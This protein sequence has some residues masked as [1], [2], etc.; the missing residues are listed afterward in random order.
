MPMYNL[1]E[2]SKNYRK[3]T[4]SLWIYYRDEATNGA[5]GNMNY[6]LKDSKIID[7]KASII[8]SV[9]DTD[10]TKEAV[11]T[12]VPLKCLSIFWKILNIPLV[13]CEISLTLNWSENCVLISKAK[14]DVNYTA[15]PILPKINTPANATFETTDAKLYVPIV[16]SRMIKNF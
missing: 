9:T 12:F 10:L 16:Q 7:Y 3:T 4:G 1:L 14:R 2:Y 11:K 8:V 13:N 6:S 15:D 5:E